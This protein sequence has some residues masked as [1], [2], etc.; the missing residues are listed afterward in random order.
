MLAMD[1]IRQIRDLYYHQG[2][3]NIS[4]ISRITGF[5]W[6]TVIKYI[7]KEDF[8]A[9]PPRPDKEEHEKKLDPYKPIIDGWLIADKKAPRKQRC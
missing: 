3:D 4:E 7:D 9:P 1:K 5:N 8:N 2:I 6:K